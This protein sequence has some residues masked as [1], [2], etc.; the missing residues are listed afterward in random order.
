MDSPRSV[1]VRWLDPPARPPDGFISR[2]SAA[3][4]AR[5][6]ITDAWLVRRL[7]TWDDGTEG[8]DVA[9]AL[10]F[11]ADCEPEHAA[12][13]N[14]LGDLITHHGFIELGIRSAIT[15]PTR[16]RRRAEQ[17]GIHIYP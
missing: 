7:F 5:P 15:V 11:E 9:L 6:D 12:L 2:V 17:L 10:A 14:F 4:A 1:N 13:A 3:L 16:M 8:E